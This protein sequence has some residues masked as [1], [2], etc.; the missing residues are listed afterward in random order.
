MIGSIVERLQLS[1][2]VAW[3]KFSRHL[4]VGDPARESSLLASLK[5][6]GILIGVTGKQVEA[7]FKPQI[8]ASRT[9]QQQLMDGWNRGIQQPVSSPKSLQREIRPQLDQIS[10]E[11]LQ[12][13][14]SLLRQPFRPSLR[15]EAEMAIQS[16]GFSKK[17][18]SIASRSFE[19]TSLFGSGHL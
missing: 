9:L 13:W 6:Q 12:E 18:A 4:G 14:R 8:E 3:S 7:L 11:M 2:E 15:R 16:H 17:I 19:S 10:R 5:S 1:R